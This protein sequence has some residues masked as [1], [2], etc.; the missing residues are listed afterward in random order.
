MGKHAPTAAA[1]P[2]QERELE[3]V[4]PCARGLRPRACRHKDKR[5]EGHPAVR[6][7]AVVYLTQQPSS[8]L[9]LVDDVDGREYRVAIEPGR[10]CCWPSTL[11]SPC[12][13]D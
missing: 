9:V 10:L 1:V 13:R 2:V 8:A 4:E 7:I 11:L 3:P 12:G 6:L 5:Q